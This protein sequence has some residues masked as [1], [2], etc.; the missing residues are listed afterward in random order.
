MQEPLCE[1]LLVLWLNFII[2]AVPVRLVAT[3]AELLIGALIS[4][5]GHISDAL[6]HVGHQKHY[7]TYYWF[8][9]HGKWSWVK[10]NI[11]LIELITTCFPRPELNLILDDFICPRSSKKAPHAKYHHEHSQKPNRPKYIWGQQ[12]LALSIAINWGKLQAALPI[13][14]RI[15]KKVGNST[16]LSRG[17]MLISFVYP[18]LQRCCGNI[19]CLVDAWYMKAPFIIPLLKSGIHVIGQVRKDTVLHDFP[20]TQSQKRKG[21]PKKYGYKWIEERIKTLPI[22][23]V[24][25]TVHGGPRTVKYRTTKCLARFLKGV[26]VIAVW[27]QY[28]K[29]KKWTLILSTDLSLT[30]ERIIKLYARRWRTEP[31]FKEIKHSFG[32]AEAWQQTS[33]ALHRWVSILCVAYS[34]M[35]MLSLVTAQNKERSLVPTIAWRRNS[36]M[37]AGLVRKGVHL[38]FRRFGF[39]LLWNPK[40]KKLI[41]PKNENIT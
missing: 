28:Q 11:K 4:G 7:S 31:M 22:R 19:R 35:R 21:R 1:N 2:Q 16:K 10:V 40:G 27:C 17:V 15:H 33:R 14:L 32:I 3:F 38:F 36:I 37:T 13:L 34:L 8:L 30:P 12:W 29:Q 23:E 41:V 9:R 39:Q 6:F 26:P 24:F 5:S 18:L 25:V 20:E